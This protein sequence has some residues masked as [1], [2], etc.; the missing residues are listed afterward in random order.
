VTRGQGKARTAML[1]SPAARA[2]LIEL[3]SM[4]STHWAQ[5]RLPA[6]AGSSKQN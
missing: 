6:L 1:G 4:G 2:A 5:L 3:S